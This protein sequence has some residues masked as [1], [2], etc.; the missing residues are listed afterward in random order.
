MPQK[1]SEKD[2]IKVVNEKL[3]LF[4]NLLMDNYSISL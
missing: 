1:D 4:N 2:L 3:F